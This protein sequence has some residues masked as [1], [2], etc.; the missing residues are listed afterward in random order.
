M[1]T[2]F[3]TRHA[4]AKEWAQRQSMTVDIVID[5]LDV[6]QIQ[7]GDTVIGSLPIHLAAEVCARGARYV[8]LILDLP[9]EARGKELAAD[10]MA[11]YGATLREFKVI[12][13]KEIR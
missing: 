4:G 10:D 2:Y 12:P 5:H 13:V 9:A 7:E 1:K 8:H 6:G 3:V 11:H